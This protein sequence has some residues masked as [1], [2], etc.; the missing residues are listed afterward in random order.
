ME[1]LETGH[2]AV[3]SI[4]RRLSKQ[5]A[6]STVRIV[7]RFKSP[8][9]VAKLGRAVIDLAA[10]LSEKEPEHCNPTEQNEPEKQYDGKGG[11]DNA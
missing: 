4:K 5:S 6:T 2:L 3:V 8:A 11:E 7:P 1:R 9:D 10:R